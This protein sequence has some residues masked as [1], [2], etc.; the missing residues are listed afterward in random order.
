VD[1]LTVTPPD[2]FGN[3]Y[4]VVIVVHATKFVFL[5]PTHTK[6]AEETA[7]ALFRFFS[8][9]GVPDFGPRL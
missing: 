2:K 6:N 5:H 8:Q 9:Y 7:L 3:E 1:T 4:I